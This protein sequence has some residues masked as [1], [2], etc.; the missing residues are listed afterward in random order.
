MLRNGCVRCDLWEIF[1][2]RVIVG[3]KREIGL[4]KLERCIALVIEVI[5]PRDRQ[6][7][8]RALQVCRYVCRC[9][10]DPTRERA[11]RSGFQRSRA[12]SQVSEM[13]ETWLIPISLID[14]GELS[15]FQVYL[16]LER[17][18]FRWL[19]NPDCSTENSDSR[20]RFSR[21]ISASECRFI[22]DNRLR[23]RDL[24]ANLVRRPGKKNHLAFW[25]CNFP[26]LG[27]ISK[28]LRPKV[29]RGS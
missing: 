17:L 13:L 21:P 10:G 28:S 9:C 2:S 29:A 14:F 22:P 7:F 6:C 12:T 11:T 16:P 4:R 18:I 3:F 5:K 25:R 26:R 20:K 15:W 24:A 27:R 23:L 8:V 19:S 1:S